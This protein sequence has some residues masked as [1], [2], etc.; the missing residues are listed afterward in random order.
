MKTP[1][2]RDTSGFGVVDLLIAFAVVTG[3]VALFIGVVNSQNMM[4]EQNRTSAT[5]D[6]IVAGVRALAGNPAALRNSMRAVSPDGTTVVNPALAACAGGTPAN[7][8]IGQTDSPF[9][10]YAPFITNGAGGPVISPVTSPS[11]SATP[12]HFDN[13]GSPCAPAGPSCALTVFTTMR[14]QCSPPPQD[15]SLTGP[16]SLTVAMLT[17][18][19]NCTIANVIEVTYTIQLDPTLNPDPALSVFLTPVTGTVATPVVLISGNLP[20]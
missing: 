16:G 2:L 15:S 5:F 8:C 6:R 13:W 17:P 14:A 12:M 7:G 10:L 4:T 20:Q 3:F 18:Q 11:D 9:T 19:S 1:R